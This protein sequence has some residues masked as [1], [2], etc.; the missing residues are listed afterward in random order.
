M[1]LGTKDVIA[2]CLEQ[3]ETADNMTDSFCCAGVPGQQRRPAARSGQSKRSTTGGAA[4]PS[5]STNGFAVQ[6]TSRLPETLERVRSLMSHP[7]FDIK[8]PNK[9]YA[10]IYAFSGNQVRFHAADGSGYAFSRRPGARAR[11]PQSHRS[12]HQ[13]GARL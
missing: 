13:H 5:S 8:V 4:R 7:A 10:L 6:S 12:L 3:Y 2:L 1:E 9:V 11:S